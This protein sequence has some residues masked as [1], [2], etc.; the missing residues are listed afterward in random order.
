MEDLIK[1]PGDSMTLTDGDKL[2]ITITEDGIIDLRL[3]SG[4]CLIRRLLSKQRVQ[5]DAFHAMMSRLWKTL[6]L[7]NFKEIC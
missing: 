6:E 5:K 2:G 7:A 4:R 1:N 3:K